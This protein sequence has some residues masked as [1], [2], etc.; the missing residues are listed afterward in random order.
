MTA[1]EKVVLVTGGSTG[2]GRAAAVAFGRLGCQVVIASRREA[3]ALEAVGLVEA[4]GGQCAWLAADVGDP[5]SA[6]QVVAFTLEKYGRLDAAFNNAGGGGRNGYL[7]EL[8]L[9]DWEHTCNVYLRSVFL[10]MKHEIAA[11]LT[12]GGGVIINNASVDGHRGF[13]WDPI[14][15][16]AKHGVLGLTKSAALQ[17]A[18]QG[19]RVNAVSPGWIDTPM[20]EAELA[21]NPEAEALWLAHQPI[22]RFGRPEEVAAAVTW[23]VSDAASLVTG[24]ALP[25]DGGYLAV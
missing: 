12:N 11:M 16:A 3:S 24:V 6:E 4:A 10:F 25:V 14:Y 23:L 1:G 9:A 8:D 2:I 5:A 20:V 22:G 18:R 19:I 13:P 17:Y 7:H 15:S 21:E